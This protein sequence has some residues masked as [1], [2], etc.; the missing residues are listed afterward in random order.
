MTLFRE[1]LLAARL[2]E[3][4]ATSRELAQTLPWVR[5][6]VASAVAYRDPRETNRLY[7]S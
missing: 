3:R 7:V 1:R 6:W 4:H 5:S 2:V